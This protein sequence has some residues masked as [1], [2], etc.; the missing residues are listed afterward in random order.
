MSRIITIAFLVLNV[1]QS[2]KITDVKRLLP[3][4]W[5]IVLYPPTLVGHCSV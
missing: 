5:V 2:W 1:F 3:P 4:H